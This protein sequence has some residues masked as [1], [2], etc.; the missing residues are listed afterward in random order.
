MSYPVVIGSVAENYA[1]VDESP[2][3]S[4][5]DFDILIPRGYVLPLP[6][7]ENRNIFGRKH[8]IKMDIP[9]KYSI[10]R[11]YVS[12]DVLDAQ[13]VDDDPQSYTRKI[14]T[15]AN[16]SDT[17]NKTKLFFVINNEKNYIEVI[18]APANLLY[19]MKASHIHRVSHKWHSYM[20]HFTILRS[21]P[22]NSDIVKEYDEY[23][24]SGGTKNVSNYFDVFKSGFDFVN[25][26]VGDNAIDMNKPDSEF[27]EDNVKR[28]VDHDLLHVFTANHFSGTETPYYTLAKIEGIAA[29]DREKFNSLSPKI[30]MSIIREE[31]VV[32]LMERKILPTL[33]EILEGNI[34]IYCEKYFER[35]LADVVANF[36]TNLCG[37]GISWLRWYALTHYDTMIKINQKHVENLVMKV[38]NNINIKYKTS[39][40]IMLNHNLQD[41]AKQIEELYTKDVH[42][43]S[44]IHVKFNISK[45]KWDKLMQLYFDGDV[46]YY[47]KYDNE[48]HYNQYIRVIARINPGYMLITHINNFDK[49]IKTYFAKVNVSN[50]DISV[51]VKSIMVDITDVDEITEHT[52]NIGNGINYKTESYIENV[53]TFS[54][55]GCGDI[56]EPNQN[57]KA[58]V[59]KYLS[60]YGTIGEPLSTILEPILKS[61]FGISNNIPGESNIGC[62]GTA[63]DSYDSFE[64]LD[65]DEYSSPLLC[66]VG[67]HR[68]DVNVF[69]VDLTK[70]PKC[71]YVDDSDIDD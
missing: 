29:M 68:V 14:F 61:L 9:C 5:E 17:P 57:G 24:E 12:F 70:Y 35:D 31:V 30:K 13:V 42:F 65:Y 2:Y 56:M 16:E 52:I 62:C 4:Y 15:A 63:K 59:H 28:Y 21:L 39:N 51:V 58:G 3:W 40:D 55:G 67:D 25:A 54:L 10:R 45:E 7:N 11:E 66:R 33:I 36:A 34:D 48:C 8:V 53:Y 71:Y 64:Y 32:L 6:S 69:S 23:F 19:V 38:L 43:G 49:I 22:S 27:F 47:K 50:C 1:R 20:R 60:Y 37:G 18:V 26:K 41:C 44:N 46:V